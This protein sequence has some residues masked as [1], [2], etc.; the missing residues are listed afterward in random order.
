M[1][2]KLVAPVAALLLLAAGASA[3]DQNPPAAAQRDVQSAAAP[4]N[5]DLPMVNQ[6]EFGVRG[7]LFGTN[8][9]HARFQRYRDL[10][11]GGTIDQFRLFKDQ[12][13]YQIRL[14]ADHVGYRDQR[15]FA[16]VNDYGRLKASFEWNQIPLFYSDST[17]TLYDTSNPG[18]LRLGSGIQ[19]GIQAGTLSL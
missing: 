8:S 5:P 15:F 9:D 12:E 14:Q 18:T 17:R 11:D 13:N 19:S 1:R 2:T 10:R 6:L 4:S 16:S 7:T 3:Q